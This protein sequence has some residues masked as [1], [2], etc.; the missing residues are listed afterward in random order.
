MKRL[1]TICTIAA[2]I[3]TVSDLTRATTL[4]VP[5]DYLTIQTAVDHADDG[6]EIVVADGIYTGTG[7]RDIDFLGKAITVCSENGPENCIID[8][9][10]SIG[11]EHR[12]FFFHSGETS[13]AVLDGFT[14]KNGYKYPGA[15]IY[16]SGSDPIIKNCKIT[17]NTAEWLNGVGGGCYFSNSFAEII[18]CQITYN[19]AI[20]TIPDNGWGGGI[21]IETNSNIKIANSKIMNNYATFVSGGVGAI[22]SVLSVVNS[23]ISNNLS[24]WGA[25]LYFQDSSPSIMNSTITENSAEFSGGGF[26]C[27]GSNIIVVNTILWGDT[28]GEI[29]GSGNSITVTYSDVQGGWAGE[30][31]I[32]DD[33]LFADADER[34]SPGSPC[35][36]AGDN[37]VVV[38]TTDLDGNPRI[39]NDIVDMGAFEAGPIVVLATTVID[40]DL[41]EGMSSNLLAKLDAAQKANDSVAINLLQAFISAVEAQRGK[42]IPQ[43]DADV[44]IAAAE[45]IIA[46][47]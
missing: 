38:S 24:K 9:Q 31:N 45:A 15:G 10:G 27:F 20:G 29:N 11:N 17:E 4:N 14:I 8:C 5:A 2:V 34:L 16:C 6:D 1:I 44:L 42:Q 21:G 47:L 30:G 12:G 22:S 35:I 28:G 43:A 39:V 18:N 19:S 26:Y 13:S 36:D 7:N 37:S 3:L 33:P 40:L 46:M 41:P 25:G 32:D 23:V